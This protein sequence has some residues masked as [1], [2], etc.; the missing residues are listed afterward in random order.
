[1]GFDETIS[2]SAANKY[3][4]NLNQAINHILQSELDANSGDQSTTNENKTNETKNQSTDDTDAKLDN[5]YISNHLTKIYVIIQNCESITKCEAVQRLIKT[6]LFY[7]ECN[8]MQKLSEFFVID[9]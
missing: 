7:K 1:M 5:K 2:M 6:L 3:P 4:K 8:D 9:K